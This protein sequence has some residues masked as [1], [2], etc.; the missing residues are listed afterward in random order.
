MSL[1]F[2]TADGPV[3]ALE[4]IDLDIADGDFVSLIG[5]SGCGKTTLLRVI[6]DLEQP[7][8]GTIIVNGI[9]PEQARAGRASTAMSSRRRR[10][11]PGARS[12]AT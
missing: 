7:T 4:D 8:A 9:T 3:L 2:A 11:T 12:S 6:A 1:T 5:P 10:C